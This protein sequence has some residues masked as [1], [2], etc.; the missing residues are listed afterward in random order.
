MQKELCNKQKA[1][2]LHTCWCPSDD[3]YYSVWSSPISVDGCHLDSVVVAN[4][5]A[6][7]AEGSVLSVI[8]EEGLSLR[9]VVESKSDAVASND[10]IVAAHLLPLNR[11][12]RQ[13]N[14]CH[15]HFRSFSWN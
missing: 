2:D 10:A 4:V 14:I 8:V 3:G 5:Q 6:I 9:G 15:I 11:N 1:T 13:S 7:D 12:A